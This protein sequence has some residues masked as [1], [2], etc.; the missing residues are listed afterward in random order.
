[1][2]KTQVFRNQINSQ[3]I[4]LTSQGTRVIV[5][6]KFEAHRSI[7]LTAQAHGQASRGAIF[8]GKVVG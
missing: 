8:I 2:G 7:G 1:M 3:G 4:V 5:C 6:S